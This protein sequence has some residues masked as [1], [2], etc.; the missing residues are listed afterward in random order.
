VLRETRPLG[1]GELL[2]LQVPSDLAP[3][4]YVFVVRT[5]GGSFTATGLERQ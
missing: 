1:K 3:G 2:R 4:T 5:S